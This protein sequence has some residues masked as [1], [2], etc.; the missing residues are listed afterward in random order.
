M[1]PFSP[2]VAPGGILALPTIEGKRLEFTVE[3]PNAKKLRL[4][5]LGLEVRMVRLSSGKVAQ[6]WPQQLDICVDGYRIFKVEERL[7]GHKRRDLP[8]SLLTAEGNEGANQG[9]IAGLRPGR[10]NISVMSVDADI[11]DYAMAIVVTRPRGIE[12][13]CRE[14]T[15]TKS[16]LEVS[17]DRFC[18]LVA[19]RKAEGGDNNGEVMCL[20]SDTLR[21]LCPITMERVQDPVRGDQCQH[22]Q[23]FGLQAY[24]QSNLR[25]R[26]FNQR[27]VC[28][29]CALVLR[30]ADLR[31]DAYMDSVL[32]GTSA[33]V[34]EVIV[35]ASGVW[36]T[37][38]LHSNSSRKTEPAQA[39]AETDDETEAGDFDAAPPADGFPA[40][41]VDAAPPVDVAPAASCGAG[42][43]RTDL[44]DEDIDILAL[45]TDGDFYAAPPA[46]GIPAGDVDAAPAVDG[47]ST[48]SCGAGAIRTDLEDEDIDIL[49]LKTDGKP[50]DAQVGA[51]PEKRAITEALAG[52]GADSD[53]IENLVF[54]SPAKRRLCRQ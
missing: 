48:A 9:F 42:A 8:L 19:A 32:S 15:I 43:I 40:G 4:E 46:D 37:M 7:D 47:A 13:L 36:R 39:L 20:S 2:L 34:E 50:G 29:L 38:P 6:A 54:T 3:I 18:A 14:V 21:L 49:A 24:L 53:D 33:E 31:R 27:W 17:R 10:S 5:R 23:C 30:P 52:D 22:L 25:M 28:P 12:D 35:S 16:S 1:D 44:E 45:K 26:A 11:T 41:D 51:Q